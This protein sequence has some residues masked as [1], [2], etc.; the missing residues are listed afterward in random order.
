MSAP[1]DAFQAVR[2]LLL[3]AQTA[4]AATMGGPKVVEPPACQL[5]AGH[6]ALHCVNEG[7]PVLT[8]SATMPRPSHST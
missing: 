3:T 7:A 1:V 5:G 4:P 6:A 8:L 2:P